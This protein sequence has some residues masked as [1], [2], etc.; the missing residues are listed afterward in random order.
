MLM[1]NSLIPGN[2]PY[3]EIF[4]N[5]VQRVYAE[6]TQYFALLED[7]LSIHGVALPFFSN[8]CISNYMSHFLTLSSSFKEVAYQIY[9]TD[10]V[11]KDS[12]T[13]R[14]LFYHI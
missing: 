2:S 5:I 14:I 9:Q 8:Q 11:L 10:Q 7:C 1:P 4:Y 12:Q 13:A 6:I 3:L